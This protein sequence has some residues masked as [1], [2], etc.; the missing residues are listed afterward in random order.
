LPYSWSGRLSTLLPITLIAWSSPAHRCPGPRKRKT[1]LR[2]R[3]GTP[4]IASSGSMSCPTAK[5]SIVGSNWANDARHFFASGWNACVS[6]ARSSINA[7]KS[8]A[9][10]A[11]RSDAAGRNTGAHNSPSR[12]TVCSAEA[13]ISDRHP[14]S[15]YLIR[16]NFTPEVKSCFWTAFRA[17]RSTLRGCN[18]ISIKALSSTCILMKPRFLTAKD[19]PS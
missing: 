13:E 4:M 1:G 5:D 16:N 3:G 10:T 7:E 18:S 15:K 9:S 6:S 8:P 12:A 17:R 19:T 11:N 2:S 14:P